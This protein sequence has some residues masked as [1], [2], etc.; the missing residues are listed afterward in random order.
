MLGL[1]KSIYI[2]EF[3]INLIFNFIVKIFHCHLLKEFD[4]IKKI[5]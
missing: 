2:T 3:K 1:H 5:S 4:W